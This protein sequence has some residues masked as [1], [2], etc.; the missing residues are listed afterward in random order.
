MI[1]ETAGIDRSSLLA[2]EISPRIFA[3]DGA[4][5]M[6]YA[7]AV[8]MGRDPL[9]RRELAFVTE[10][11][12]AALPTMATVI[13]WDDG[14]LERTGLD[15]T[16]IVHGEQRMTLHR[17]LLPQGEVSSTVK[18]VEVYDRGG[19]RGAALHVRTE[20]TDVSD[21]APLATLDSTI[22]ARGD[23]GIGGA[24]GSPPG[25]SQPP[26]REPDISV[27]QET[28]PDQA[29]LYRL[30]G[31]RN[32]LHSDPDFARAAGFERPILHGLCTYGI[33]GRALVLALCDYDPRALAQ[34]ECRFSAPVFPGDAIL[35][36]IWRTDE[37]AFFRAVV[38][39]R[40]SVVLD[41]GRA[42]LRTGAG[43][44]VPAGRRGDHK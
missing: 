3:Y 18:V 44:L 26:A 14:W 31:D 32:P 21:G 5:T 15:V 42:V 4:R 2:T 11:G 39:E 23:T 28:R 1:A 6:L 29:L 10:A 33:A 19:D 30:L 7:L 35:T 17:P 37:G 43:T 36:Q 22:L 13:A 38:P 40:D 12:L 20:L 25:L 16:R 27:R 34:M 24:P 9:D 41:L 8:G